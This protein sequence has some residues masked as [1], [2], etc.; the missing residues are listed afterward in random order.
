MG[1]SRGAT[2][3]VLL[4]LKWTWVIGFHHI[5]PIL[6]CLGCV[7]WSIEL[8]QKSVA[9]I[10]PKPMISGKIESHGELVTLERLGEARG[11]RLAASSTCRD[12]GVHCSLFLWWENDIRWAPLAAD[13]E[14]ISSQLVISSFWSPR[15]GCPELV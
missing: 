13:I 4:G 2:P 12:V 10:V 7:Q 1:L 8:T 9:Y 11:R 15:T 3:W 6:M 14:P 5:F